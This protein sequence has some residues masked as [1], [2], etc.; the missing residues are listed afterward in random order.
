MLNTDKHP[1]LKKENQDKQKKVEQFCRALLHGCD[2]HSR[3]H[4]QGRQD[5]QGVGLTYFRLNQGG[6]TSKEEQPVQDINFFLR[7][8][9]ALLL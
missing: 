7:L 9:D 6:D 1:V 5:D 3:Q 4:T 2:L 8:H